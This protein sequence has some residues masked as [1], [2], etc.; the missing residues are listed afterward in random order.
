MDAFRNKFERMLSNTPDAARLVTMVADTGISRED[1]ISLLDWVTD[2]KRDQK[3]QKVYTKLKDW[4]RTRKQVLGLAARMERLAEDTELIFDH[5][6]YALN[7]QSPR[8]IALAKTLKECA[9]AVRKL[10]SPKVARTLSHKTL[11]KHV[12][13][14]LFCIALGVPKKISYSDAEY[15]LWYASQAR[16]ITLSQAD[17]GLEREQRRFSQSPGGTVLKLLLP[18]ISRT[19]LPKTIPPHMSTNKS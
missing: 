5:P 12:P 3:S 10:L 6:I 18:M 1:L 17:R 4:V 2:P 11:W 7:S 14:T 13:L 8:Y 19:L 16:G 15:L 9:A